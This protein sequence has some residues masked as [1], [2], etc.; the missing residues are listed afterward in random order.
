M[1]AWFKFITESYSLLENPIEDWILMSVIGVLAFVIAY[2]VVG[3][4]Y[5]IGIIGGRDAGH[6][7]HWMIRFIVF[8][9][10]YSMAAA[11]IRVY[12]WFDNL[13]DIKWWILGGGV[14]AIILI[15]VIWQQIMLRKKE[16][17]L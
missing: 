17:Y 6:I 11:F 15:Y 5:A 2:G 10:I 16:V 9:G 12:V 4:L 14:V 1:K 7:L 13:P 3:K 8:V